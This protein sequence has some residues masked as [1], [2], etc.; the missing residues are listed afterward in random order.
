PFGPRPVHAPDRP[1]RRRDCG[2]RRLGR[3]ERRSRQERAFLDELPPAPLHACLRTRHPSRL[4]RERASPVTLIQGR[5]S[6]LPPSL[7]SEYHGASAAFQLRTTVMRDGSTST[8]LA[9]RKRWPWE[10]TA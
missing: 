5:K 6:R 3:E 9:Y 1:A 4:A 7:A 2:R 10:A 8:T